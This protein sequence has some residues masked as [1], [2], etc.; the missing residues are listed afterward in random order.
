MGQIDD[1][2]IS[3]VLNA[4]THFG[5]THQSQCGQKTRLQG[6]SRVGCC[7]LNG[8]TLESLSYEY[9]YCYVKCIPR[10]SVRRELERYA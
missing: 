3:H 6:T 5:R 7:L 1:I 8:N 2:N 4:V 9:S 10:E